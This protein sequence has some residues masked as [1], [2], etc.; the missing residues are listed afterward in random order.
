MTKHLFL[1]ATGKPACGLSM[2]K[3]E[4]VTQAFYRDLCQGCLAWQQRRCEYYR[5]HKKWPD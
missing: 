2:V 3:G 5:V 1:V 4:T